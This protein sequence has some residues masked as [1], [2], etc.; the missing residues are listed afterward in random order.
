MRSAVSR[1]TL[2]VTLTLIAVVVNDKIAP[3]DQWLPRKLETMED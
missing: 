1:D 2:L 3:T